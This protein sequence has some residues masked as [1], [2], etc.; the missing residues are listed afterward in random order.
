MNGIEHLSPLEVNQMFAVDVGLLLSSTVVLVVCSWLSFLLVRCS[1]KLDRS[2]SLEV[3]QYFG[4]LLWVFVT[5][6][7]GKE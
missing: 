7:R 5:L 6:Q 4:H 1:F 2:P 3:I